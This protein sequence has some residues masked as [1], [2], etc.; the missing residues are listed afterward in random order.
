M[1]LDQ[2]VTLPTPENSV[3]RLHTTDNVAVARVALSPGQKFVIE[4]REITA[5]EPVPAGHKVSLSKVEAGG[6]VVRYGQVVGRASVAIE[7]G[8]HVHLH[9]VG[10]ERASQVFH[11]PEGELAPVEP[12]ASP[13]F[14]GYPREDGRAGTRNYVAIV[15]ASSCA[16]FTAELVARGFDRDSLPENVHGVAT[17]PHGHGCSVQVGPDTD[18]LERTIAGVLNHPNVS[19]AVILGLGCEVN[20]VSLYVGDNAASSRVVGLTLQD[21]GGTRAAAEAARKTIETMIER[22]AEEKRQEVPAAKLVLG[23]QCGGS[24]A[25]SGISA[26]PALGNCCDRLITT[27]GSVEVAETTETFGAEHLLVARSRSRQVA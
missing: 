24:D 26:N 16:A 19:A 4:G 7:P 23:L 9:N 17:F 5:I 8:Q 22:A 3:V 15:S 13:T 27:G 25:F 11:F 6:G 10:L 2:I 14:Q 12:Q 18:Q 20:Q 21:S 1:S